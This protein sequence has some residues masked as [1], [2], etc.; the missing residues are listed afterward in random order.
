MDNTKLN[1]YTLSRQWFDWAYIGDPRNNTTLGNLYF[2]IIEKSNRLNWSPQFGLPTDEAM[3]ILGIKN[4]KTYKKALDTL[5]EIGFI[6]IIGRSR[7]QFTSNTIAL[8]KI[9]KA[10]PTHQIKQTQSI[11]QSKS[12]ASPKLGE[13]NKTLETNKNSKT[14]KT[15]TNKKYNP[16]SYEDFESYALEKAEKVDLK[17]DLVKLK[18]KYQSWKENDWYNGHGRKIKNWKT[19]LNNTLPYLKQDDDEKSTS[20]QKGVSSRKQDFIDA[21]SKW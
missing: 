19:T 8:V 5:E 7:N 18:L 9:T 13:Y 4:Y 11:D 12:E 3:H 1:S 2:W 16:P 14:V 6:Q 17:I 21:L 10:S 20:N 15:D